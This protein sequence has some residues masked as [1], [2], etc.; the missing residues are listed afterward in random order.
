MHRG[1]VHHKARMIGDPPGDVFAMMGADIIAYEMNRPDGFSNLAVQV[2]QK[3]DEF[4]LAFAAITLP[5]DEPGAGIEGG[6]EV[7]GP[8]TR[9]FMLQ[10]VGQVVGPGWQGRRRARARLQ[11]GLLIQREDDLISAEGTRVEIDQFRDSGIKS[12]IPGLL[13][14]KPQMMVPGLQLMGRQNP[15]HGRG[16]DIL[17]DR[18]SD[19]LPCQFVAIPLGETAAQDIRAFA[20]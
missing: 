3:G 17:D 13:G 11:R 4:F 18:L 14:V 9:V 19:K 2:F 6:K 12:G 1:E 7:E 10:A 8:S 15:P 20:G 5:V 16:R